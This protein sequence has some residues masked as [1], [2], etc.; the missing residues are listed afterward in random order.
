MRKRTCIAMLEGVPEPFNIIKALH[1]ESMGGIII[2]TGSVFHYVLYPEDQP[3]VVRSIM[4]LYEDA[5]PAGDLKTFRH[6]A[7][8][9][10]MGAF[11]D[12]EFWIYSPEHGW[13]QETAPEQNSM[14]HV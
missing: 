3:R 7:E 13:R 10:V 11:E 12:G 9:L 1:D 14:V 6:F 5:I 4:E 2:R 8:K